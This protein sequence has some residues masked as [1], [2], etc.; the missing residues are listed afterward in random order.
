MNWMFKVVP[1]SIAFMFIVIIVWWLFIAT[2][3]VNVGNM[4]SENG[5]KSVV[6]RIW[7]GPSED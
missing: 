2:A 7:E 5:L 1:V 6:E 4:I 3:A